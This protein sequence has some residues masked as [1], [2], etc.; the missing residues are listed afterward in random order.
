[1]QCVAADDTYVYGGTSI[2][3]GRGCVD[4]TTEGKLFL[5]DPQVKERVFECIPVRDAIAITSLAVAGGTRKALGWVALAQ[6]AQERFAQASC[7]RSSGWD[8][9]DRDVA[10]VFV[11]R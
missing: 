2:H 8:K 6:E 7:A 10:A 11:V 1:M 5:F 4:V 3:G 9:A